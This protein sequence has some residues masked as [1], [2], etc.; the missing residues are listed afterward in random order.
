MK[1]DLMMVLWVSFFLIAYGLVI[2]TEEK[3]DMK[4]SFQEQQS[5]MKSLCDSLESEIEALKKEVKTKNLML[6]DVDSLYHP[7]LQSWGYEVKGTCYQPVPEQCDADPLTTAD[8][9][10]IDP[11]DPMSHRWVA[12]S[13]DLWSDLRGR[14]VRVVGSGTDFDGEWEVRDTM[15]RRW[16]NRIDFLV[17]ED[18]PTPMFDKLLVFPVW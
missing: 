4:E 16:K 6:R 9:S 8:G 15:N 17:G 3:K 10:R 18:D 2:R 12:V 7:I 5:R 13:R 11:K 14:T 1:R